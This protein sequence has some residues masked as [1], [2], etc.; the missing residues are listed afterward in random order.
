MK[1]SKKATRDAY[2]QSTD[3]VLVLE[4]QIKAM[5]AGELSGFHCPFCEAITEQ[6]QML[7][8]IAAGDV[9]AAILDQVEF[10]KATQI[11]DQIMDH[12]HSMPSRVILN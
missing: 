5:L 10:N 7:C 3:K 12:L 2:K 1:K 6:G 8:C 9:I 11:A 4:A